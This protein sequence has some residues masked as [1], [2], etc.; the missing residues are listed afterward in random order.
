[1]VTATRSI[2]VFALASLCAPLYA[3]LRQLI[4][5][6]DSIRVVLFLIVPVSKT[7][8]PLFTIKIERDKPRSNFASALADAQ[9]DVQRQS[10]LL[11]S[12]LCT[13]IEQ[14]AHQG[15]E[16]Q[17]HPSLQRRIEPCSRHALRR[18]SPVLRSRDSPSRVDA[19]CAG[20]CDDRPDLP[21]DDWTAPPITEP[22]A[23][24][25]IGSGVGSFANAG[26]PMR[27]DSIV[28]QK[29]RKN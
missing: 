22:V 16:R 19:P 1:L 21:A 7:G 5:L 11:H 10:S 17:A 15:A 24:A 23:P 13:N 28:R 14:V 8:A 4:S 9:F 18:K 2:E 6:V 3:T 25:A 27:S 20:T 29:Q 12:H 26:A